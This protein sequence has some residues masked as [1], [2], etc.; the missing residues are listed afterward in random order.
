MRSTG[1]HD[2]FIIEFTDGKHPVE[3]CPMKTKKA[4]L[5]GAEELW[6]SLTE[7]ERKNDSTVCRVVRQEI[8]VSEIIGVVYGETK[9]TIIDYKK[10]IIKPMKEKKVM[11]KY[12]IVVGL[13][14][15]HILKTNVI[16]AHDEREAVIKYL[17]SMGEEPTEDAIEKHLK[18]VV[19][20]TPKP[21]KKKES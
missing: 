16:N 15:P 19:V 6:N 17:K 12:K 1:F 4:A 21:R 10:G 2:A 8:G 20:H 3:Q 7:E 11:N 13:C 18:W 14:G 9:E 5:Q